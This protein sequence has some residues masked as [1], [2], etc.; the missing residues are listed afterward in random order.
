MTLEEYIKSRYTYNPNTGKIIGPKNK[1]ILKTD[2]HGYTSI[3]LKYN[4]K[5]YFLTAHRVGWLLY[6]GQWPKKQIDHINGNRADNRITNLRDVSNRDNANNGRIHRLGRLPGTSRSG[7]KWRAR[8]V[9]E[10]KKVYIGT[11][12]TETDAHNAYMQ[13]RRLLGI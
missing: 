6:Y 2:N 11:F 7:K 1:P 9:F 10:K 4:N 8:L 3:R 12:D 5:K 13:H